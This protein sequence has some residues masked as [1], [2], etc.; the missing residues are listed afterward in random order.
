MH[1]TATSNDQPTS[2]DLQSK[3]TVQESCAGEPAVTPAGQN[4]AV[5]P[6][7]HQKAVT[8]SGQNEAGPKAGLRR[9]V[10][11]L[12]GAAILFGGIIGQ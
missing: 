1:L 7:P 6:N 12:R 11:V 4:E 3:N 10:G 9:S 5:P 8:P 2:D